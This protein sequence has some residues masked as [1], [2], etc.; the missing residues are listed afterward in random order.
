MQR[1]FIQRS[2]KVARFKI[3]YH[4]KTECIQNRKPNECKGKAASVIIKS[5]LS[6]LRFFVTATS[7]QPLM[8]VSLCRT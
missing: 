7:Q 5:A 8:S 2:V 3:C 1:P 4:T 6:C